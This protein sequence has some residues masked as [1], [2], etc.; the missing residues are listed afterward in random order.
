MGSKSKA[1][2][3]GWLRPRRETKSKAYQVRRYSDRF[4]YINQLQFHNNLEVCY[5]PI[6]CW[7][8]WD[9]KGLMKATE[10]VMKRFL[11]RLSIN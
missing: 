1:E 5:S 10:A 3:D 9:S 11:T 6:H 7:V 2:S 4:A 8:D